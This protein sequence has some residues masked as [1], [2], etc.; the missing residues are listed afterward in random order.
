MDVAAFAVA[1]DRQEV[2]P[3]SI[4]GRNAGTES[5]LVLND[6]CLGFQLG[7]TTGAGTGCQ[8]GL[9]LPFACRSTAPVG[10]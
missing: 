4:Q 7:K 8:P 3:C 9:D 2:F 10:W 5:A 6:D 1:V